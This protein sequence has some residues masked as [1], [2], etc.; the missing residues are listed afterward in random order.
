MR[1]VSLVSDSSLARAA[2]ILGPQSA[3][4]MAL[5]DL[6]RR[7]GAGENAECFLDGHTYV[8]GVLPV[9]PTSHAGGK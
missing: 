8:I 2:K 3:A 1:T 6:E 9:F 7:R 5:A 4:A